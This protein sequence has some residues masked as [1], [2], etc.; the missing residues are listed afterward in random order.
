MSEKLQQIKC[1]FTKVIRHK[2]TVAVAFMSTIVLAVLVSTALCLNRVTVFDGNTT[3]TF[4]SLKADAA[5]LTKLAKLS[6]DNYI[7]NASTK[8]GKNINISLQYM[9]PVYITVGSETKTVNVVSGTT[10]LDA[11][12]AAGYSADENDT[13]NLPLEQKLTNTQ[14]IDMIDV[15]YVTESYR[16]DIA[17]LTKTVYSNQHC[18]TSVTTAGENGIKEITSLVKY[19]NGVKTDSQY[20]SETVLKD[21]VTEI[22]TVGT[23]N[24]SKYTSS[25]PAGTISTLTPDSPIILD[26]NGNPVNYKRHITVQAT[27]Y[28][29]TGN[30]SA[31]GMKLQPGCVAINTKLFAYGTKFYIKS[32]DGTYIYGYA[33][34]ADT[35]GFVKTRP[36]NFDLYFNSEAEC[37]K[38]GRRNIEVYV[39]D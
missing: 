12:T 4:L 32:S 9:F 13:V 26:E 25:L 10:V 37:V 19:V 29:E 39:L 11:I 23:K 33:V 1:R 34:A 30:G 5:S 7:I 38:F 3:Q 27:A 16:E 22:T 35:G 20:L 31:S 15:E 21:A 14:Y 24:S 6:S 8:S 36:T 2:R 18:D 28:T 17:Y